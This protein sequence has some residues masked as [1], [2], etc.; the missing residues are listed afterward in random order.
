MSFGNPYENKGGNGGNGGGWKGGNGGGGWNK[1]GNS[2]GGWN[3]GGNG[4]GKGGFQQRE[5]LTPEQLARLRLPV[6]VV[7]TGADR[8]PD[9]DAMTIDLFVK[10][11]E[12]KG[13]TVRCG[14]A[15][16]TDKVVAK[17]ARYPEYHLPF[18]MF[19]DIEVKG[20]GSTFNTDECFEF[21]KRYF[22]GDFETANKFHRAN[23][24][25]NA[26][27]LFG[28][29]LRSPTQ[30]VIVWSEDGAELASDTNSR[31]GAT[32]HIIR[33]ASAAGIPVINIK[34]QN[35]EARLD[36]FLEK[37]Y[38]KQPAVQQEQKPTQGGNQ[39]NYG[40]GSQGGN[41]G[42]YNGGNQGGYNSGNSGDYG[43][44]DIPL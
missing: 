37:I 34:S 5:P 10:K 6:S 19:D 43:D 15:S 40:S 41:S 29:S 35:A 13:I 14:A 33:M 1:G 24:A 3:K 22:E 38:V 4:G 44:E 20:Y 28:K 11:I 7:V 8:I 31:S 26:R 17:S 42:G 2:G 25:K 18:K 16:E 39:G 21:A 9:Q 27:L 36:S 32:G 23:H 30:L 12:A